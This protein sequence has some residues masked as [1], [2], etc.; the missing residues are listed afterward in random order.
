MLW[1]LRDAVPEENNDKHVYCNL[2]IYEK[3]QKKYN[4]WAFHLAT[5]LKVRYLEDD[6][7]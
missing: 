5:K 4:L 2:N 6:W 1:N 3:F 7:Q